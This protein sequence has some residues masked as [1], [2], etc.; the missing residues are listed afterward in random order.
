M[1]VKLKCGTTRIF[2]LIIS[3]FKKY[4]VYTPLQVPTASVTPEI[5]VRDLV[6]CEWI[7]CQVLMPQIVG[8]IW[9]L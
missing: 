2:L 9:Y 4:W 8:H 3:P 1:H 7:P 5:R 6:S